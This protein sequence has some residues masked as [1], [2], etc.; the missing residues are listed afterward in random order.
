MEEEYTAEN[1]VSLKDIWGAVKRKIWLVLVVTIGATLA[2]SLLFGLLINPKAVEYRMRF[3]ILYPASE[4]A[5]YPDG[6]PFYDFDIVSYGFLEEAKASDAAFSN[7]DVGRMLKNNEIVLQQEKRENE[8]TVYTVTI[9]A[10]PFKN[11]ETAERFLRAVAQV[12]KT[13]IIENAKTVDYKLD[14][15]VFK[16]ASF[17]EKIGL[18]SDLKTTLLDACDE[19]IALYGAPYSVNGRTLGNYRSAL[20]VIYGESTKKIIESE[21]E[22]NG[23]NG[24]DISSYA[25]IDDAVKARKTALEEE[26][27]LNDKIIAAL[28]KQATP[29][30]RAAAERIDDDKQQTIVIEQIG[31]MDVAEML[32]YY[33]KRNAQIRHQVDESLTVPNVE[34]YSKR[35]NDLFGELQTAAETVTEI[36]SFMY[37]KNTA[38]NFL[39]HS[40][41]STGGSSLILVIVATFVL[42]LLVSVFLAYLLDSKKRKSAHEKPVSRQE[43]QTQS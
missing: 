7:L 3:N 37:E 31:N 20:Y 33:T 5:R 23:Y 28:Q 6:S 25:T 9:K 35:L 15:E 41:E 8:N 11:V 4:S 43:E 30:A 27:K 18:L 42:S 40:A 14:E 1:G 2:V 24:L 22:T 13:R 19:W 17:E 38:I 29:T 39:T 32:A 10:Q 12:P 34:A 16:G 36:S 26:Y 21:F